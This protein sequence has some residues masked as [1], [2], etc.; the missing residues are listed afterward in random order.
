MT[1]TENAYPYL[2]RE[3]S[4]DE[5][6]AIG[7]LTWEGFGYHLPGSPQPSPDR[8]EL[9]LDAESRANEGV[10]L[11]AEDTRTGRLLATATVLPSCSPLNE[12]ART[13]ESE[14]KMLA[15]LPEARR[16]GL[17]SLLLHEAV[18]VASEQGAQRLVLD[19]AVDNEASHVF[20]RSFGF[21]RR[22]DRERERPTPK[23]QLA[24]F[25]FDISNTNHCKEGSAD[26]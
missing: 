7:Q 10:L 2:I 8:R 18:R 17:G 15:V 13:G 20:Y 3:A 16:T 25:T 26:Q 23:V 4:P 11:V 1:T 12:Q 9:L 14:L 6:T 22:P 19:T 5:Y 21:A 24:V